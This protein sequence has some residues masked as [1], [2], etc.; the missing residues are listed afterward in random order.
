MEHTLRKK[1]IPDTES[2]LDLRDDRRNLP[3]RKWRKYDDALRTWGIPCLIDWK[4]V[5]G[6]RI[7]AIMRTDDCWCHDG[8]KN[9]H[10]SGTYGDVQRGHQRVYTPNHWPEEMGALRNFLSPIPSQSEENSNNR[11]KTG[12]ERGGTNYLWFTPPPLQKSITRQSTTLKL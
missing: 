10:H 2:L 11:R 3:I 4:I 8:V 6:E 9:Y 5:K 7:Q 1:C 12:I